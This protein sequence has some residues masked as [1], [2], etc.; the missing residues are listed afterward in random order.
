MNGRSF[1]GSR[2]II[3]LSAGSEQGF[4]LPKGDRGQVPCGTQAAAPESGLFPPIL[5]RHGRDEPPGRRIFG[6]PFHPLEC[7]QSQNFAFGVLPN[8]SIRQEDKGSRGQM[9]EIG[10]FVAGKQSVGGEE[11]D[12]GLV[13]ETGTRNAVCGSALADRVEPTV[14]HDQP[15]EL[16]QIVPVG[17]GRAGFDEAVG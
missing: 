2:L 12:G 17:D 13:F 11:I 15:C 9:G 5:S 6:S 16:G 8:R 10:D 3:I 7:E 1:I 4:G 14:A